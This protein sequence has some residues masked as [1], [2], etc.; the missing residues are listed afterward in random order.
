M[1]WGKPLRCG[2]FA[3]EHYEH[4]LRWLVADGI[5]CIRMVGIVIRDRGWRTML[6]APGS[7]ALRRSSGRLRLT[8]TTPIGTARVAWQ[9]DVDPRED[10]LDVEATIRATGEVVTNRTGLVVL[11]PTSVHAG[12]T[13]VVAHRAGGTTRGKLPTAI[14]PHQPMLDIAS[15]RIAPRGGPVLHL[16]FD[17]DVFEMEDQ[18]N[19]LDPTFKLY[20]RAI[21]QPVPYRLRDGTE[22]RHTLR[23]SLSGAAARARIRRVATPTGKVP[24][25]GASLPEAGPRIEPAALDVLRELQ[26]AFV[27]YR[28]RGAGNGI[29]RAARM[30]Q[31]LGADLHLECFGDRLALVG[32]ATRAQPATLA[33]HGIEPAA[34][35]AMLR[36]IRPDA[37]TAGTF[38]DFVMVNR[39]RAFGSAARVAFSLCPTV[40]ARDDRTLVESLASLDEVFAQAR[41]LAGPRAVDAGPA[42]LLRRLVPRTGRPATLPRRADGTPYDVDARQGKAI[43]AAWLACAIAVAARQRVATFCAFDATGARG[44]LGASE[45]FPAPEGLAPGEVTPA[46]DVMAALGAKRKQPLVIHALDPRTGA[47]FT[48]GSDDPELWLVDLAG[49][50]RVVP[51]SLRGRVVATIP[52]RHGRARKGVDPRN[53]SLQG[54]G[55]VRCS[56]RGMPAARIAAI[57]A[58][59]CRPQP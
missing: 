49:Q 13:F 26:L 59:W 29:A 23:I 19:W 2:P 57:V 55:I 48:V 20:N 12:A 56:V 21:A 31:A 4:S 42:T 52:R 33:I 39:D 32:T 7:V 18:R 54:Y 27:H 15:A 9:L 44:L 17:G 38:A 28:A 24:S 16:A 41:Q 40:H 6:P 51:G 46:F 25:L 58:A 1:S 8:G 30:A 37:A 36:T 5:E 11:L 14:A 34:R 22:V 50:V 10:G 45:S 43:A 35:D 53:A 47:A 3:M